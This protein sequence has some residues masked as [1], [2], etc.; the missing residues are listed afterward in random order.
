MRSQAVPSGSPADLEDQG[1]TRR[2]E[3]QDHD[4][5]LE[6][7]QS[8]GDDEDDD[9]PQGQLHQKKK[10]KCSYSVMRLREQEAW[11][12]LRVPFTQ[13]FAV[14]QAMPSGQL[15]MYCPSP[16]VF[17]CQDCS[18]IAYYCEEC[19]RSQHRWCNILHMPQKCVSNHY[20]N[21]PLCGIVIP[22]TH[23]CVSLPGLLSYSILL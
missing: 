17:R 3:E 18:A 15:C 9:E 6:G 13:C 10:K 2:E 1:H 23:E 8:W 4:A 7:P 5:E 19:C 16:A 21:A 11:E 20:S 14:S 22:V 12:G